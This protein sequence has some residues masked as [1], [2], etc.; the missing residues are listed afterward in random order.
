MSNAN[1]A[2]WSMQ[3]QLSIGS[4]AEELFLKYHPDVTRLDGRKG[5][6]IG[7][8]Q[9]KIELKADSRSVR[10]T[11]NMFVERY[12]VL[13]SK[14]AGGPW[15]AAEH[16]VYY[17]VYL[18]SCGTIYWFETAALIEHLERNE[19]TYQSRAIRNRAWTTLGY[20]V[21]RASL[22]HLIIKKENIYDRKVN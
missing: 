13:S 18:F 22:E 5:D 17:F 20:L 1:D 19:S 10:D 14:K 7:F 6:F 12:S 2:S 16:E 21:P 11:P 9:K 4:K 8:T 15:Q 3:K